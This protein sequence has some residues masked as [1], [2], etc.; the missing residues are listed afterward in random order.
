MF[1]IIVKNFLKIVLLLSCL[2]YFPQDR[3]V[4]KNIPADIKLRYTTFYSLPKIKET[5]YFLEKIVKK[6]NFDYTTKIQKAINENTFIIFP[7]YNIYINKNGLT[8]PSNKVLYF[9]KKSK[10]IFLGPADSRKSDILKLYGSK[11]VKIYNPVIVGSKFSRL[12]Q[13]GEWSAGIALLH[14]ENIKIYNINISDTYGDGVIFADG[15][16]NILLLGG[17][18]NNARRDGVSI[19]SAS[20]L[21]ISNLV[22]ANTYGTLPE[23]G[24]QIEPNFSSDVLSDIGISNIIGYNNRNTTVSVNLGPLN[25]DYKKDN[26]L[27]SI[28][29]NNVTDY[30]SGNTIAITKNADNKNVT[31]AGNLIFKNIK[32]VSSDNFIWQDNG[33]T[34]VKISGLNLLDK[35]QNKVNI[36]N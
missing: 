28:S 16:K 15:S 14:A 13:E 20:S 31:P 12:K 2:R 10:I 1:R 33:K 6:D 36:N 29:I 21:S 7:N 23:C 5:P 27:V 19:T 17:I 32:S 30:L 25:Q 18:I 34:K 3:S 24:I 26:P 11:N 35:M 22:I 4:E 9:Q 8:I